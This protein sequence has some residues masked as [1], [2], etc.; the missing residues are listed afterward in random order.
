AR[1]LVH[2]LTLQGEELIKILVILTNSFRLYYQV[3]LM[4]N[5]GWNE[6]KQTSYLKIHPYRVKLANQQVRNM[7]ESF[8][9]QALLSL[10]ELDYKIKSSGVDAN[11]LFDLALIKLALKD[12]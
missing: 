10:I 2:D 6:Q 8:L 5:K 7:Q 9:A 4:Q 12:L 1:D 3:K 11:Y